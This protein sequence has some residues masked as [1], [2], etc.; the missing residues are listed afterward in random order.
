[1]GILTGLPNTSRD[2]EALFFKRPSDIEVIVVQNNYAAVTAK[3]N[4][5]INIW[6]NDNDEIQ[7]EVQCHFVTIES[8][9]FKKSDVLNLK[10]WAK[11][12][13]MKIK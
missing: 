2:I 6:V 11:L 5:A 10:K 13:L 7:C 8:A 1:M 12:W 4:G 9:T 3:N